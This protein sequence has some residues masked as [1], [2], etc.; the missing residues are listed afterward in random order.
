MQITCYKSDLAKNV[1]CG[2]VLSHAILSP[3]L[4]KQLEVPPNDIS[5]DRLNFIIYLKGQG[6]SP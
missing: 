3:L 5:N 6:F 4:E 2:A 1:E